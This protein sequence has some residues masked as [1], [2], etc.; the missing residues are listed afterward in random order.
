MTGPDEKPS[1]SEDTE[2]HYRAVF[3]DGE[4]TEGDDD[5]TGHVQPPPDWKHLDR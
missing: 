2:G 1:E 3:A 4:A 5:V